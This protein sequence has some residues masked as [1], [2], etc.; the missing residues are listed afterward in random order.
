MQCVP[1]AKA[2]Q[3][4]LHFSAGTTILITKAKK[5]HDV[6]EVGESE[7]EEA[8]EEEEGEKEVEEAEKKK[9]S[10]IAP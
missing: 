6:V 8:E 3:K 4:C 2:R 7:E 5:K 10:P 1:C 9:T